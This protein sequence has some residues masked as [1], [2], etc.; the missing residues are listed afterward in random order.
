MGC[1]LTRPVENIDSDAWIAWSLVGLNLFGK[2]SK[3]LDGS[4]SSPTAVELRT[5]EQEARRVLVVLTM[6]RVDGNLTYAAQALRT[7]RRSLRCYLQAF[8]LYPWHEAMRHY[9][10]SIHRGRVDTTGHDTNS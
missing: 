1:P 4:S 3:D 8:G 7:S 9:R 10:D 2:A 5:I 6:I